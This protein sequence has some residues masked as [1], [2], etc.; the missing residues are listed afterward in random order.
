MN[1]AKATELEP[2]SIKPG[3]PSRPESADST[4]RHTLRSDPEAHREGMEL[5]R[6]LHGGHFG[7]QLVASLNEVCPDFATMTVE[8]ALA[9][10]MGRPGLD[11][12]TRELLLIASCTTLGFAAPQ[13]RAHIEAA[14]NSGATREQIVETILQM[15]FYAGG[16]A[17]SNALR[18]AAEVFREE[19]HTAEW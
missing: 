16:A 13:L 1:L 3:A 4:P 14:L 10:V 18:T 19:E 6:R 15:L 11:L 2:S 8:W 12:V 17:V 7:E 9:G 5:L